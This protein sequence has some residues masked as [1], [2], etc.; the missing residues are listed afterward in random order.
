VPD[1]LARPS[2]MKSHSRHGIKNLFHPVPDVRTHVAV[3]HG[4]YS[5]QQIGQEQNVEPYDAYQQDALCFAH[6]LK[7]PCPASFAFPATGIFIKQLR[8]RQR[9][10][11][12]FSRSCA[13]SAARADDRRLCWCDGPVYWS[14]IILAA[15]H[16]N[17]VF[18]LFIALRTGQQ[19]IRFEPYIVG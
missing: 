10:A 15:I 12:G 17:V 3:R 19:F 6:V 1:L 5:Q 14:I 13:L 8:L 2:L 18:Q 9:W 11:W 4:A 16:F 7:T